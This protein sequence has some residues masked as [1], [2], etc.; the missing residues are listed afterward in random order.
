MALAGG[1]TASVIQ[2]IRATT[3]RLIRATGRTAEGTARAIGMTT[4]RAIRALASAAGGQHPTTAATS[5]APL[6]SMG[7]PA[8]APR[9]QRI[10][11]RAMLAQRNA[12]TA[13]NT[14]TRPVGRRTKVSASARRGIPVESAA[15]VPEITTKVRRGQGPAQSV[16][17]TPSRMQVPRHRIPV[18]ALRATEEPRRPAHAGHVPWTLTSQVSGIHSACG[19]TA[20]P[21]PTG[22]RLQQIA[23]AALAMARRN[24]NLPTVGPLERSAFDR[25]ALILAR[26]V[27]GQATR[28]AMP[29]VV[30]VCVPVCVLG[31]SMAT[32]AS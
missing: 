15:R 10:R 25:R 7:S 16:Q 2:G 4:E 30:V 31:L 14:P 1:G 26:L 8:R 20:I 5:R 17:I 13:Q 21:T 3:A 28:S 29:K 11:T 18:H 27:V 19:V 22:K 6:E 23:G 9:A 24:L 32:R 12:P